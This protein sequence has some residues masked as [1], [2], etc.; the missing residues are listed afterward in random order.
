MRVLVE[1]IPPDGLPV[2]LDPAAAWLQE[3]ASIALERPARSI[4]GALTVERF[5]KRLEVVGT[6]AAEADVTCD[7]CLAPLRLR[8]GGPVE[9]AYE[10]E[11][12]APP[13][14]EEVE[15]VATDLDV[16]WY[17]GEGLDMGAVV[18]EQLALWLPERVRC[19]SLET[20]RLGDE[21]AV[22][23]LPDEVTRRDPRSSPFAGIRLPK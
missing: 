11:A 8:L 10:P 2:H 23:A 17:D 3:A 6:M 20:T 15:L 22:C 7:R 14:D 9:L 13:P 18:S 5:G 1:H 4:G 21:N 16:G 19:D 12:K